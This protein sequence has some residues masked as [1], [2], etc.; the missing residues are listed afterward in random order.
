MPVFA[1]DD[2]HGFPDP[3]HANPDGLLAIGGDLHPKRLINAYA[4]GI[5]PWYDQNSPILWWSPDPRLVLFP[6]HF[7]A[8]RSLRQSV[9]TSGFQFTAD[10]AF[11]QVIQECSD[12]PRNRET[13]TWITPEMIQAYDALHIMGLAH[14]IEVWKEGTLVG[15]LYG[16][17]LGRAF[18]GESMFFKHR[19]A[20]KAALWMLCQFLASLSFHFI[21]AQVHTE[22]LMRMGAIEI[23]RKSFLVKLDQALQYPSLQFN[24]ADSFEEFLQLNTTT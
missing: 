1:L 23:P 5:F 17:S 6:D 4:T 3:R 9:R 16:V 11:S 19:D 22:H 10:G 8:T 21:D 2:T 18:F 15:G 12:V 20:S 14:S 24:W 13:G 7:R